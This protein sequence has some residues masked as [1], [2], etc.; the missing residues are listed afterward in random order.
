[1]WELLLSHK[2]HVLAL[3]DPGQLPPVA[4]EPHGS[5]RIIRIFFWMKL[6]AKHKRVKSFGLNYGYSR[7][8]T[9]QLM[10]G[11]EVRIVD[12]DEMLNDGCLG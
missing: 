9:L 8:E 2:I 10:R 7:A 5:I 4:A 12:R 1:M 11:N 3:G 6:C